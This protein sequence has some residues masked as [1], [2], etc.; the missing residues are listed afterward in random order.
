MRLSATKPYADI[1]SKHSAD[2]AKLTAESHVWALKRVGEISKQ[3]D[4]EC[5]YR[6]L[7]DYEISQ[8][9]RGDPEHDDEVNMLQ[10]DVK[11]A[12]ELGIPAR[13]EEGYAIK[14]WD[15]APDQRDAAIFGEQATFHP[16]TYMVG[17]LRR[18]AEQPNFACYTH[19]RMMSIEEKSLISKEVLVGTLDGRT[20]TRKNGSNLHPTIEVEHGRPDG[21]APN[22]LHRHPHP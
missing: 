2:G 15:G 14:G 20:I 17:V 22:I 1:A 11:K 8:Y 21:I 12:S 6:T 3:L 10:E 16:T 5:G 4:I 7:P 9:Q 13:Y 19:S 18:L